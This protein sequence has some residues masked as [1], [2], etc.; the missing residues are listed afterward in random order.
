MNGTVEGPTPEELRAKVERAARKGGK[1]RPDIGAMSRAE[2]DEA[3]FGTVEGLVERLRARVKIET[4]CGNRTENPNNH[5]RLMDEAADR[6][7]QLEA[8]LVASREALERIASGPM[9]SN[10][11]CG[12]CVANRAARAALTIGMGE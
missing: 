7:E 12:G 5:V 11:W 6:I 3:L 1:G 10:C 8:Q 9:S 2:R 4:S